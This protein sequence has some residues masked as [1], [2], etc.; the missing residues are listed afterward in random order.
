MQSNGD[1]DL[2]TFQ[3]TAFQAEVDLLR[4]LSHINIVRYEGFIQENGY[5]NIVLE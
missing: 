5:L 2:K 4:S 3:L 1:V